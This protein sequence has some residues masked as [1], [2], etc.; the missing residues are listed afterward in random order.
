MTSRTLDDG[1][2]RNKLHALRQ[3]TNTLTDV[4]PLS[5]SRLHSD[6]ILAAAV[7]RLLCRLVD[8]AVDINT[9][10]SATVLG[11]APSEYRESFER[12]HESGALTR[13]L[14]DQIKPSVGLRNT[15][16]HEY[17]EIDYTIVAAA[18]LTALDGYAEYRRQIARFVQERSSS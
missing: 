7:E 11:R 1:T 9:H 13:D 14:V 10:I 2:I 6:A 5:A 15:I 3:T 17:V 18:V 8:L 16:V 12:A 4:T